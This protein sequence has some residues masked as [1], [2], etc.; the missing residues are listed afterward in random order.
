MTELPAT[1]GAARPAPPG[2][3]A[4]DDPVAQLLVRVAAGDRAAFRALY[5]AAAP[6]LFGVALRMLGDRGEAEDVLQDTF[7]R[8]W[9]NAA[10]FDPA[11]GRG[12]TWLIAIARNRAIDRLRTRPDRPAAAVEEL[13]AVA[14]PAPGAEAAAVVKGDLARLEDCMKTLDPARAAAVRGAYLLGLSYQELA[15]RHRVPLNT[16]RTWLRRSLIAL[17]GCLSP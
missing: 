17:R 15:D 2:A 12:M 6:K 16:M 5:A 14:D 11:K 4:A 13:E 9:T 10:R 3:G 7:T 8:A 1:T